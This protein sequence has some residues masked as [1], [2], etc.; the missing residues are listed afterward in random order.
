M[1]QLIS[2]VS[3]HWILC[4]IFLVM[5]LAL[6]INEYFIAASSSGNLN[7]TEALEWINHKEAVVLDIR[8][9]Q[10]FSEGHIIGSLNIPI[11]VFDKKMGLLEKFKDR[12][13]I[14][15][16]N[17]GQTSQKMVSDLKAKGFKPLGL[18]GGILAWRNAGLPLS[19]H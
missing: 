12:D 8:S 17:A 3:Q 2:F 7:T 5:L 10:Q 11:E 18:S 19:K 9:A 13:L 1:E 4:S 6:V 14:I 16:C 15:V